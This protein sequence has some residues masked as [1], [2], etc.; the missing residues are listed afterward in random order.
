MIDVIVWIEMMQG[1]GEIGGANS[2]SPADG[3]RGGDIQVGIG[4]LEDLEP[5]QEVVEFGSLREKT[6]LGMTEYRKQERY[7]EEY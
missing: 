4:L 3:F 2:Q 5:F 6:G 7:R 1:I